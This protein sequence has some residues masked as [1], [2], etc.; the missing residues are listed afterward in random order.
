MAANSTRGKEKKHGSDTPGEGTVTEASMPRLERD[1]GPIFDETNYNNEG[2]SQH[3]PKHGRRVSDG[4]HKLHEV[5]LVSIGGSEVISGSDVVSDKGETH[6]DSFSP[7]S[8]RERV[9]TNLEFSTGLSSDDNGVLRPLPP[10]S[11]L[12]SKTDFGIGPSNAVEVTQ[13]G[14]ETI[15]GNPDRSRP[16]TLHSFFDLQDENTAVQDIPTPEDYHIFYWKCMTLKSELVRLDFALRSVGS[17]GPGI[18][19]ANILKI[20]LRQLR[21]LCGTNTFVLFPDDANVQAY[22]PADSQVYLSRISR[23]FEDFA[24]GLDMMA[25]ALNDFN[26]AYY[27]ER[28]MLLL[29]SLHKRF[30]T[31]AMKT[32]ICYSVRHGRGA[33][34]L[35]L[36]FQML[37]KEWIEVAVESLT[38]AVKD[39]NDKGVGTINSVQHQKTSGYLDM[40]TIATFFSAVTATMIQFTI[41]NNS[42]PVSVATN[43]F[44][45]S[46]LVFSIGSAVNSLLVTAWRRSFVREPNQAIPSWFSTWL[47]AGPMVS[48]VAAGAFFSIAL[49]LLTFSS[50]QH[51]VTSIVI[52]GFSGLHAGG[53]TLLSMF[54]LFEKWKFRSEAGPVGR[55][56]TSNSLSLSLIDMA[57]SWLQALRRLQGKQLYNAHGGLGGNVEVQTTSSEKV[58]PFEPF[59]TQALQNALS[60]EVFLLS[61][62][63]TRSPSLSWSVGGIMDSKNS[64]SLWW[65]RST[66][67]TAEEKAPP[68]TIV[69][70]DTYWFPPAQK[71]PDSN[72]VSLPVIHDIMLS[73]RVTPVS[74]ATGAQSLHTSSSWETIETE[75]SDANSPPE[76]DEY[77]YGGDAE[78]SEMSEQDL[79]QSITVKVGKITLDSPSSSD[80][81]IL[82]SRQP[83]LSDVRHEQS[84]PISPA[85]RRRR[86]RR[87]QATPLQNQR[88]PMRDDTNYDYARPGVPTQRRYEGAFGARSQSGS[89]I[90]SAAFFLEPALRWAPSRLKQDSL[91]ASPLPG[92]LTGGRPFRRL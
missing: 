53:L 42:N 8:S 1:L 59:Q 2:S 9:Y 70:N 11:E 48:L 64:Y 45:F 15:D 87:Y 39:F 92:H 24:E 66:P 46:S 5:N 40:T 25:K 71:V 16:R 90:H 7:K 72:G 27:D 21:D 79:P 86:R 19:A 91:T 33:E 17:S 28:L 44:M 78:P 82:A 75:R 29:F 13:L 50:S 83:T 37:I 56:L 51:L 55:G 6:I 67:Q 62:T 36:R 58:E 32:S 26:G 80:V 74:A 10:S 41:S 30:M 31:E 69:H 22:A 4:I 68:V 38:V 3:A 35:K 43:T 52:I 20:R 81:N 65:P 63:Y 60:D 54:F 49:C 73:D 88:I 23:S 84:S 89:G 34:E 18:H 77:E 57:V 85:Q 47:N 12:Q 61:S 76:E 14:K